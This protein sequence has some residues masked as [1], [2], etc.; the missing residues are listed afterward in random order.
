MYNA[1]SKIMT[2]LGFLAAVGSM[3]IT[4]YGHKMKGLPGV[5][6]QLIGITILLIVVYLYNRKYKE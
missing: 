4:Y 5:G 3:F 2:L 1:K 6:V